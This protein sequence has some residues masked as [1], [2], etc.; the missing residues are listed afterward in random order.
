MLKWLD[1]PVAPYRNGIM[2][3]NSTME[4][5]AIVNDFMSAGSNSTLKYGASIAAISKLKTIIVLFAFAI[6][7]LLAATLTTMAAPTTIDALTTMAVPTTMAAPDDVTVMITFES[8]GKFVVWCVL[9]G[10]NGEYIPFTVVENGG[11]KP[12]WTF[13]I[14]GDNGSG[15]PVPAEV[16]AIPD[17]LLAHPTVTQAEG[18]NEVVIETDKSVEIQLM[19]VQTGTL[20]GD[21][22]TVNDSHTI[23]MNG[24]PIGCRYVVVI[25]QTIPEYAPTIF[26]AVGV[27]KY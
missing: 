5:S 20:I 22:V 26:P 12:G 6:T 3:S 7:L 10:T 11:I 2:G 14:S 19:D 23:S 18:S 27:C 8:N 17:D 4:N 24:L 15:T 9:E 1:N 13:D 25:Y 21:R 16:P